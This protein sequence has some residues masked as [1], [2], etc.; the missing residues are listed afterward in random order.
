MSAGARPSAVPLTNLGD[1][2]ATPPKRPSV[3]EGS[4]SKRTMALG[5]VPVITQLAFSNFDVLA[6][7]CDDLAAVRKLTSPLRELPGEQGAEGPRV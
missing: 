5:A 1:A 7:D 6:H 2:A 3:A 4:H